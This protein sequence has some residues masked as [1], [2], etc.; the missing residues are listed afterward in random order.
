M[1]LHEIWQENK[2]WILSCVAGLLVFWI[3]HSII[4]GIYDD[5]VLESR[6]NR[7][8]KEIA[9]AQYTLPQKRA[10][11]DDNEGIRTAY[12]QLHKAMHLEVPAA[13]RLGGQDHELFWAQRKREV[14]DQLLNLAAEANV[15][16]DED[17]FRWPS[18]V[19]RADIERAL[20]GLSILDQAVQR[21]MRAH[22]EV[23]NAHPDAIGLRE[24]KKMQIEARRA[25]YRGPPRGTDEK[26]PED[27]ILEY[28]VSFEVFADYRTTA[29]F[30]ESCR[31]SALPL[32]LTGLDI[33]QTKQ[34]SGDPLRV[35]GK[36]LGLVVTPL[37]ERL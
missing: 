29:R 25:T 22:H 6:I 15:D 2:R 36:L 14:A 7:T 34:R 16:L 1:D 5:G 8:R 23:T 35:R 27:Q 18:P 12:D 33:E 20:V 37:P 28:L 32:G 9:E 10:A 11:E 30:L 21:L 3:G 13:Y 24:V 4:D 26:R 17:A 31:Q 19:E